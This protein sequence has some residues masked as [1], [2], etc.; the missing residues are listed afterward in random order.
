MKLLL[1]SM[2]AL[3]PALVCMQA[4]KQQATRDVA[5]ETY[6]HLATAILEIL[7]TEDLVVEGIL[8]HHHG[9]ARG[10]LHT[11]A[12]QT[13]ADQKV[14]LERA[15][16]EIANIANEG[17]KPVQA[18]RQRLLKAGHTHNTDAVTKE[19]YMFID[20]TEKQNLLAMAKTVGAM[21]GAAKADCEKAMSDLTAAF[22]KAVAT[23]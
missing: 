13:G 10:Y 2:V 22:Q 18:I 17:N 7:A 3:F 14:S 15:A 20:S 5:V 6:E 19:D 16:E 4:G 12:V 21:A 23:Q 9:L 11:A 1:T 8:T